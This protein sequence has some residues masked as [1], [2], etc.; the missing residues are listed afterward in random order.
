MQLERWPVS[1]R[2]TLACSRSHSLSV[3]P[4]EPAM[5]VDSFE[6]N[7]THSTELVC[8]VR[9]KIAFGLPIAHTFTFLSS[10]PVTITAPLLRPNWRQLTAEP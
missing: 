6:S 1:V 8:P 9:L 10:P 2:A 7:V 3:P 4:A 5:T